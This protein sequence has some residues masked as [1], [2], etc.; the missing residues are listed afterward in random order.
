VKDL[1]DPQRLCEPLTYSSFSRTLLHSYILRA[2]HL[3]S[4]LS[5]NARVKRAHP[6][7]PTVVRLAKPALDKTQALRISDTR[8]TTF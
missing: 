6:F 1:L 3:L 5:P 4:L 8:T 7:R 2:L